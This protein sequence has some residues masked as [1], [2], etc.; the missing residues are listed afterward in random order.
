MGH[1]RGILCIVQAFKVEERFKEGKRRRKRRS[2][3]KIC[4]EGKNGK[5]DTAQLTWLISSFIQG[6]FDPSLRLDQRKSFAFPLSERIHAKTGNLCEWNKIA[7]WKYL[8]P[9]KYEKNT[10]TRATHFYVFNYV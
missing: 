7:I 8:N 4:E 2:G 9:N 3:R 5:S 10:A 1:L 6:T